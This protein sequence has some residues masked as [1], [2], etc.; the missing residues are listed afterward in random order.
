MKANLPQS[1]RKEEHME[2][3]LAEYLFK[4][5]VPIQERVHYFLLTASTTFEQFSEVVFEDE[6][7]GE[8]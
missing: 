5:A 8:E 1:G 6:G 4:R 2:G 3:Y 7:H